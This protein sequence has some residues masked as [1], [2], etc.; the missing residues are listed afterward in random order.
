MEDI[1]FEFP[2][3]GSPDVYAWN[4]LGLQFLRNRKLPP[5]KQA[6]DSITDTHSEEGKPDT[7]HDIPG[8]D[9]PDLSH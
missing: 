6:A 8:E 3:E 4:L 9:H 2:K 7:S 5:E 1:H